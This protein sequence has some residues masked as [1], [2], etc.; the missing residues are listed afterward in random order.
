M[1]KGEHPGALLPGYS[2]CRGFVAQFRESPG[3]MRG[4]L[5]R[6]GNILERSVFL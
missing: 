4:L 5:R 2:Y 3:F 1:L 6:S